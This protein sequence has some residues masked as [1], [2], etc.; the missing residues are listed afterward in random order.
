[1]SDEL[2][3]TNNSA[4]DWLISKSECQLHP[5]DTIDGVIELSFKGRLPKRMAED[6]REFFGKGEKV[7][8]FEDG[9]IFIK[10]SFGQFVHNQYR[11]KFWYKDYRELAKNL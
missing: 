3:K 10:A 2:Y 9:A 8:R 4:I 1:M 7:R 5:D 6:V 11:I